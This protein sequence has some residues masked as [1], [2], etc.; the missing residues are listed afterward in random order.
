MYMLLV[1]LKTAGA[2]SDVVRQ[3]GPILLRLGSFRGYSLP[4]SHWLFGETGRRTASFWGRR[5]SK[6]GIKNPEITNQ[7]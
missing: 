4:A 6:L 1:N 2:N 5:K 7:N 3:L